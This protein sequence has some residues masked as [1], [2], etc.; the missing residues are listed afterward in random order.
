M[1]SVKKNNV[2]E[3]SNISN[4]FM[5]RYKFAL[6]SLFFLYISSEKVEFEVKN[7]TP[8]ITTQKQIS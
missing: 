4:W 3:S 1:A 7:T 8:F 2:K 6:K 5:A